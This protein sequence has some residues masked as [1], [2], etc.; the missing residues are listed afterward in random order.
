MLWNLLKSSFSQ[1]T[2]GGCFYTS[3]VS[4]FV[5]CY[6]QLDRNRHLRSYKYRKGNFLS[7]ENTFLLFWYY[8]S[9]FRRISATPVEMYVCENLVQHYNK[10]KVVVTTSGCTLFG[11]MDSKG[12]AVQMSAIYDLDLIFLWPFLLRSKL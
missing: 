2:S 8:I 3:T 7:F 5:K 10:A 1:N 11:Q 6:Y 4:L 9:N 12:I